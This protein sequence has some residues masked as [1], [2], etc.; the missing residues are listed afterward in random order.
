MPYFRTHHAAHDAVYLL[1]A[2]VCSG[3]VIPRR[4]VGGIIHHVRLHA[5]HE[6]PEDDDISDHARTIKHIKSKS[7]ADF[8]PSPDVD[9]SYAWVV[10]CAAFV[11]NVFGT[12]QAI[13]SASVLVPVLMAAFDETRANVSWIGSLGVATQVGTGII[14]GLVIAKF[15][16]RRAVLLAA[17]LFA[18]GYVGSGF[19]EALWHLYITS[20]FMV[21]FGSSLMYNAAII[22]LGQYFKKKRALAF[23]CGI[24]GAGA[25]T[26]ICPFVLN[27]M[28]SRHG[29]RTAFLVSAAYMTL[30]LLIV[31][32]LFRPVRP[33][34]LR[35]TLTG[36]NPE[37]VVIETVPAGQHPRRH[38][39]YH[40]SYKEL[41]HVTPVVFFMI[42]LAIR[43]FGTF[44]PTLYIVKFATDQFGVSSTAG[45]IGTAVIGASSTIGRILITPMANFAKAKNRLVE[46]YILVVVI[47]G[48]TVMLFPVAQSYAGLLCIAAAF[49]STAGG[50][51]TF[52]PVM[53]S[54]F[55]PQH[56]MPRA[57]GLVSTAQGPTYLIG[58]PAA[59]WVMAGTGSYTAA[60]EMGGAVMIFS[61]FVLIALVIYLKHHPPE[62]TLALPPQGAGQAAT[63]CS[64][65]DSTSTTDANSRGHLPELVSPPVEVLTAQAEPPTNET[66]C[67]R[68][69]TPEPAIRNLTQAIVKPEVAAKEGQNADLAHADRSKYGQDGDLGVDAAD[70]GVEL[71]ETT[72]E[73]SV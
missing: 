48:G 34:T 57:I 9:Q 31:A 16:T 28:I 49:G 4:M 29:W 13:N 65:S 64:V 43:A 72:G 63:P 14:S 52:T 7:P 26:V 22:M 51:I 39:H 20:G 30:S 21:G 71:F 61:S 11:G 66:D 35:K 17:L 27:E 12:G 24:A 44:I 54:T 45:A 25:G 60:F 2:L 1:L 6:H 69:P 58:S 73:S 62:S 10:C 19:A 67:E 59:G 40:R 70:A 32:L 18:V 33:A 47:N 23:G 46:F 5:H 53:V 56:D 50:L 36:E 42:S 38:W 55:V 8:I 37:E 41:A 68:I 3:P 15:G